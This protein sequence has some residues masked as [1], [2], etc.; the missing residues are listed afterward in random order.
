VGNATQLA[1]G[2]DTNTGNEIFKAVKNKIPAQNLWYTKAVANML[3]F[4]QIQDIIAPSYRDEIQRKAERQHDRTRWL[5]D[6]S[7]RAPDFEKAI[8][9]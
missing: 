9:N 3:I 2:T 5:E 8:G 6:D 7:I 4:N 1:N